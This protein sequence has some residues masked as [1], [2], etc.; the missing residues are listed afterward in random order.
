MKAM[1]R[2]LNYK[3]R[4]KWRIGEK[5]ISSTSRLHRWF[6][7]EAKYQGGFTILE[8]TL[9]TFSP[10]TNPER[11]LPFTRNITP[12]PPPR[13]RQFELQIHHFTIVTA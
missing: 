9:P 1:E 8:P 7:H 6:R 4:E 3:I 13:K 5:K 10:N 12:S 11:C 2:I